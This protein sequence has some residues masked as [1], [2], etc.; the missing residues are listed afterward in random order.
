MCYF[1]HDGQG[2]T[3]AL[4]NAA[5]VVTD[6][7]DYTAFGDLYAQTGLT[8]TPYLYTGQQYDAVTGLYSLRARY[9]DPAVGR[10][11]GRDKFGHQFGY[12]LDLNR[13]EYVTSNPISL[14]DPSGLS[15]LVEY[16]L[17]ISIGVSAFMGALF[18]AGSDVAFQMVFSEGSIEQRWSNIDKNSVLVA[19]FLGAIS[20]GVG[21]TLSVTGRTSIKALL[22]AAALW[23]NQKKLA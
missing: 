5:G 3:R 6:T 20:G 16:K 7:Y 11:L 23:T 8:E 21:G 2:S 13:Y 12:P 17:Q 4:T 22:G 1:L 18:S 14:I 19:A 9:Y 10:F 15:P